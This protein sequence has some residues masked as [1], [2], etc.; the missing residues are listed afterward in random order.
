MRTARD[1]ADPLNVK[2]Q[3]SALVCRSHPAGEFERAQIR[4]SRTQADTSSS[5]FVAGQSEFFASNRGAL[6]READIKHKCEMDRDD[7][8]VDWRQFNVADCFRTTTRTATPEAPLQV[9]RPTILE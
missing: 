2:G 9:L 4:E 5:R 8:L 3:E 7:R 6:H 1:C